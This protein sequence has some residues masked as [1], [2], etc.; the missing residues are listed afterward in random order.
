[1][2]KELECVYPHILSTYQVMKLLLTNAEQMMYDD[3]KYNTNIYINA[4]QNFLLILNSIHV[5]IVN[6]YHYYHNIRNKKL[7][8]FLGL[9][10]V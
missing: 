7:L 2:T 6:K 10:I 4:I 5:I 8:F 3:L 1:M 9:Q